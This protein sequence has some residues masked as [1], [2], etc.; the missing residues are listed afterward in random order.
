M[1][2]EAVKKEEEEEEAGPG[3]LPNSSENIKI[4]FMSVSHA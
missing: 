2:V 4:R 3:T 1:R